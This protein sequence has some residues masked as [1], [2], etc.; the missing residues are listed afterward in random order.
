MLSRE[1]KRFLLSASF[2]VVG[3]FVGCVPNLD[4]LSD[5][6]SQAGGSAGSAGD[7]E[8][9]TAGT[10]GGDTAGG[11]AG[12]GAGRGGSAGAGGTT[13]IAGTGGK[14]GTGGKAGTGG[15]AGAAEC[16]PGTANCNSDSSC[17]TTLA[18]GNPSGNTVED[19]GACGVT[20]SLAHASVATCNNGVC[21]P[22]CGQ[23]FAS[24]NAAT[25]NDG[26]ETDL[27]NAFS[28][29]ICGRMCSHLGT[30]SAACQAGA[31]KPVCSAGFGDCN[32][33]PGTGTDDGCETYLDSLT[34]CGTTCANN[35]VACAAT[36]VCNAGACV[37]PQGMA[38]LT[39]HLKSVGQDQRYA[40]TFTLP[41]L[42]NATITAR[43]YAPGATGGNMFF[44]LSDNSMSTASPGG[45]TVSLDTLSKGWT[46]VSLPAGIIAG[47]WDP[48]VV[49]QLTMEVNSGTSVV[50]WTDPTVIYIDTVFANNNTVLDT[51]DA[52]SAPMVMSSQQNIPNS[53]LGWAATVP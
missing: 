41:N 45:V 24:C 13:P 4:G 36:K 49:K 18:V 10:T 5:H 17:E 48:T 33:D 50:P 37:A 38:V 42:T 11:K 12:T 27:N 21:T 25:T 52:A 14:G 32:V 29:G 53:A 51:F 26:C 6:F 31:C 19:C 3:G 44:Y 1:R 35:T 16:A 40:D 39:V 46:D 9:G 28:C 7:G 8:G 22:M 23:G 47:E 2:L 15:E 43:V 34:K 30:N 20:C